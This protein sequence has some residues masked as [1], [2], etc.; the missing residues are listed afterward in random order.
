MKKKLLGVLLAGTLIV[1][2]VGSYAWFSDNSEVNSDIKLTM[3]TLDVKVTEDGDGWKIV[4]KTSEIINKD[5][6]KHFKNVRPGDSFQRNFYISNTGTLKQ[7]VTVK[8]NPEIANKVVAK[9]NGKKIKFNELFNLTFDLDES[10]LSEE[11]GSEVKFMLDSVYTE[12]EGINPSTSAKNMTVNLEI[13]KEAMDNRFNHEGNKFV[14]VFDFLKDK[15]V[16]L[17]IVEAEQVNK[18]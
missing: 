10:P 1:G 15:S 3:G 5:A 11:K 7:N 8:L 9:Y 14:Q 13:N 17:V 18:E 16:P 4:D 12:E 6:T 2:A